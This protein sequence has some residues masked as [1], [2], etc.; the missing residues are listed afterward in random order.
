MAES[1]IQQNN[2][3]WM[4]VVQGNT[5]WTAAA[6]SKGL[7]SPYGMLIIGYRCVFVAT[8]IRT[9]FPLSSLTAILGSNEI[10]LTDGVLKFGADDN[11][12]FICIMP[13]GVRL[14]PA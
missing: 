11:R 14:V 6:T 12:Q 8:A 13:V 3:T 10:S 5:S 4:Y 7:S 2:G 9:N 1:K